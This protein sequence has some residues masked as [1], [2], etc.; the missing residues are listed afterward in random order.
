MM[1]RS[2]IPMIRACVF[3]DN[4]FDTVVYAA[5]EGDVLYIENRFIR[6]LTLTRTVKI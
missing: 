1:I 5:M 3:K 6:G 4:Y 2:F